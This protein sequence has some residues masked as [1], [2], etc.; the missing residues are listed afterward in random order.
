L[1]SLLELLPHKPEIDIDALDQFLVYQAVP[2]PKTIYRGISALL[3][4]HYARF[5][6]GAE[7]ETKRY[8]KL[9]YAQKIRRKEADLLDELDHRLRH[10][11]ARR[12][13]SD[14]PLGAFLSG[15]VDSS[16]IVAIMSD[17]GAGPVEAIN[18][19]FHEKEY[20]E[21]P[22]ARLVA[23]HCNAKLHEH[24]MDEDEVQNLP[25]ILWH[26]GQPHADVSIVPTYAVARA[27]R[28]HVTVVLNGDGGDE[29][30]AGYARPI[31]ARAAQQVRHVVPSPFL[32]LAASMATRVGKKRGQMLAREL[33][34]SHTYDRGIRPIRAHLYQPSFSA[35]LSDEHPDILYRDVWREAD[36]PT[37]VDRA[38]FSD[39]TTYLPDQLL[40]KMD[41][42]TMA[43]SIEAR[44]PLLDL[45]VL[46]FAASVPSKQLTRGYNTK[47]LLKRLAE[48]YVPR[49]VLYRRKRGF[50]MPVSHWLRTTLATTMRILL[51]SPSFTERGIFDPYQVR[52]M[53]NEHTTAKRDWGEVLWSLMVLEIWFRMFVDETLN[54]GER[55]DSLK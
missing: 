9:S 34:E 21:R 2:A 49:E 32:G 54:R 48:K 28:Q 52:E 35:Q 8:W 37:D 50:V 41:V 16:L 5:R 33:R 29:A 22:F 46:T 30:F 27:A 23:S 15:G 44:S 10:A 6:P 39:M 24:V 14:V 20:D 25:A 7:V 12:L 1:N 31:V 36:G 26:Y 19:G 47:P 55:L 53:M 51:S 43:H 4:A 40:T 38:L 3:P 11:V 45:G 18:V 17:L 42:S 13:I